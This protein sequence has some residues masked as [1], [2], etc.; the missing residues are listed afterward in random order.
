MPTRELVFVRRP[1]HEGG[2]S[3]RNSEPERPTDPPAILL[4]R[5]S[6]DAG[7]IMVAESRIV[8]VVA[9]SA[10]HGSARASDA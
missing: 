10:A 9:W 8:G 7:G 5:A 4:S 3:Q 2:L 6:R 1:S